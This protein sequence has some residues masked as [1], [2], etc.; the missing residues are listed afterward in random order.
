MVRGITLT[1][2]LGVLG[3]QAIAQ[4]PAPTS[5][6][7]IHNDG[8]PIIVAG[9]R[10]YDIRSRINGETYRVMV[11]TPFRADPAVAY[12]VLYVLDGNSWFGTMNEAL[13]KQFS[14]RVTAP[15]ILVAI[16]YPTDDLSEW[17]S[18]RNYDLTFA[19]DRAPNA[20]GRSGGADLFLRIIEE[21]IKPFV[22]SR[23]N[24]DRARQII[25]GHSLGGLTAL[26]SL[27]RNPTAF[28][29]YILSSPSIW[30]NDRDV[31]ADEEA[32]SKRARGRELHLKILI[33]SAGDEQYRGTDP[34]RLAAETNRQVDNA[35]ALAERLKALNPGNITVA[36]TI[37]DGEVH[38]TVASASLS[39]ALRFALPRE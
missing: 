37:F 34:Q 3:V 8:A 38:N 25:W 28:S 27:F 26:R 16:G 33:T 24:V 11:S 30:Y 13:S 7:D 17:G 18:R 20:Q 19:K 32:F 2:I 22:A 36:R 14:N 21:E 35:S 9:A 39:R 4:Q 1:V 5:P 31:L 6:P 15:A 29:T 10:Q 12:P 23:Y